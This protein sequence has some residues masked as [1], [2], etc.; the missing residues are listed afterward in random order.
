MYSWKEIPFV[1]GN[2]PDNSFSSL[3]PI[4]DIHNEEEKIR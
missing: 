3:Y 4:S 2:G 1:N